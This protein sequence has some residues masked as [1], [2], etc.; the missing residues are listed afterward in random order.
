MPFT[1]QF[2]SFDGTYCWCNCMEAV[3]RFACYGVKYCPFEIGLLQRKRR[4]H[5]RPGRVDTGLLARGLPIGAMEHAKAHRRCLRLCEP[6]DRRDALCSSPQVQKQAAF[7]ITHWHRVSGWRPSSSHRHRPCRHTKG[8]SRSWRG[9]G[10]GS[11][12]HRNHFCAGCAERAACRYRL[13][14]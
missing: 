4:G 3:D 14:R 12:H 7:G 1:T 10:R 13:R 2:K 9:H 11:A 6:T 8:R 5:G